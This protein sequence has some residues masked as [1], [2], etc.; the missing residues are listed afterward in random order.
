MENTSDPTYPTSYAEA[1]AQGLSPEKG[2]RSLPK[3]TFE[4]TVGKECTKRMAKKIGSVLTRDLSRVYQPSPFATSS[5]V[6]EAAE[7][8]LGDLELED[9]RF[10]AL[11][12]R[13]DRSAQNIGV[14]QPS[15]WV[16]DAKGLK[17]GVDDELFIRCVQRAV[18]LR[19]EGL[20][21]NISVGDATAYATVKRMSGRGYGMKCVGGE[22]AALAARAELQIREDKG[23]IFHGS[24]K[25]LIITNQWRRSNHSWIAD[26][27][28]QEWKPKL[29]D[30]AAFPSKGADYVFRSKVKDGFD[31]DYGMRVRIVN[32]VSLLQNIPLIATNAWISDNA[33]RRATSVWKIVPDEYIQDF[34]GDIVHCIDVS[35]FEFGQS[36]KLR[37]YL[38]SL[39]YSE[40]VREVLT[41]IN[42]SPLA[43]VYTDT[44][45][46]E[47]KSW[48]ET[49]HWWYID[50]TQKD[51]AL[52]WDAL[53]SGTGDTAINNGCI[54]LSIQL[55]LFS[56]AT[57]ISPEEIFPDT[58]DE[59]CIG[60]RCLRNLGDDSATNF[61]HLADF[62]YDDEFISRAAN[63]HFDLID[64][65]PFFD[66][67]KEFPRKF[68]GFIHWTTPWIEKTGKD[69]ATDTVR[70]ITHDPFSMV[71]NTLF[72]EQDYRSPIASAFY[73]GLFG[74]YTAYRHTLVGQ[75]F[76]DEPKFDDLFSDVLEVIGVEETISD[77]PHKAA[78][79][80]L[81]LEQSG[82]GPAWALAKAVEIL[83]LANAS[84]LDYKVDK[85][86][87]LS[88]PEEILSQL[89]IRVPDTIM[90][91][92]SDFI[93]LD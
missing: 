39:L 20:L 87:L 1:L 17:D 70:F 19:K 23:D 55:Y 88:L 64:E 73:S 83:G 81:E 91:D 78:E 80:M 8:I 71:T 46:D 45:L 36:R 61:S 38:G 32:S 27:E 7:D 77:L 29:K 30:S 66:L 22:E 89:Y 62:G 47:N 2:V 93:N 72:P 79:E 50:R 34:T 37:E 48:G 63:K 12:A 26:P 59:V 41:Y 14:I 11:R 52:K 58:M 75:Q 82:E 28:T 74:R 16:R 31:G 9:A 65:F 60:E 13:G 68:I 69:A 5:E 85:K 15:N 35:G 57:G 56:S 84:E 40:A 25:H 3:S 42:D 4:T 53:A 51:V 33:S 43:G 86:D 24:M 54:G 10:A 76:M 21:H 18:L 49:V 67:T 92:P 90:S 44:N 6:Q